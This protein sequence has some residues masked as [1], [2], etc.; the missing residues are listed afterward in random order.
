METPIFKL[1]KLKDKFQSNVSVKESEED[2]T[3]I[4]RNNNTASDI[5]SIAD[6]LKNPQ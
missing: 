5:L 4:V 2:S 1:T 3:K 6:I